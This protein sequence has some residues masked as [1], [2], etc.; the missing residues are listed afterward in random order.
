MLHPARDAESV[1]ESAY[2]A[3]HAIGALGMT[4]IVVGMV[5]I[6]P[7]LQPRTGRSGHAAYLATFIG[8]V[9]WVGLLFLDAFVNPILAVYAAD[10][11][12][13]EAGMR[14]Q[15]QLYGPAL[16]LL[17]LGPFLFV[18]GY[19]GFAFTAVSAGLA[20][21]PDALLLGVGAVGFGGGPLTPLPVE[22]IGGVVFALG[23]LVMMIGLISSDAAA[24][25]TDA[26][27]ERLGVLAGPES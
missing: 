14:M 2:A 27:P 6:A 15:T 21:W 17:V 26:H 4:L 16:A 1:R 8:S 10:L 20:R 7:L 11:M 19:I 12:H 25:G 13:T 23:F 9:L 3:I 22:Q 18:A 5:S 24:P